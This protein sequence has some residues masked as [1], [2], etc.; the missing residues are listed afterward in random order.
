MPIQPAQRFSHALQNPFILRTGQFSQCGGKERV[1]A[2]KIYSPN[3]VIVKT[4]RGISHKINSYDNSLSKIDEK[5][6]EIYLQNVALQVS[7]LSDGSFKL[8]HHVTGIGGGANSSKPQDPSQIQTLSKSKRLKLRDICFNG[9]VNE[10]RELLKWARYTEE[11]FHYPPGEGSFI[12]FASRRGKLDL[13]KLLVAKGAN[14]SNAANHFIHI[15]TDLDNVSALEEATQEGHL[16]VVRYLVES[17]VKIDFSTLGGLC[18]YRACNPEKADIVRY[19]I[20]LM[21]KTHK[22]KLLNNLAWGNKDK[23]IELVR[24]ELFELLLKHGA[25][26]KQVSVE[27]SNAAPARVKQLLAQKI[28]SEVAPKIA[29]KVTRDLK[30]NHSF[31]KDQ[32]DKFSPLLITALSECDLTM[33]SDEN[34]PENAAAQQILAQN[35]VAQILRCKKNLANL[36]EAEIKEGFKDVVVQVKISNFVGTPAPSAAKQAPSNVSQPSVVIYQQPAPVYHRA[37]QAPPPNPYAE[38]V[39]A[40]AA[41]LNAIAAVE[42]G[43]ANLVNAFENNQ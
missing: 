20:P 35:L 18:L 14:I 8:S 7:A 9:D 11:S 22:D 39:Q 17:G 28:S 19:L 33:M 25:D 27:A 12:V 29:A 21:D 10:A 23:S 15:V 4:Q 30:I 6:L 2:L 1:V 38:N 24:T 36:T 13:I 3:N 43:A 37:H 31:T 26:F 34:K 42:G 16:E 40:T 32:A 5:S 41:M